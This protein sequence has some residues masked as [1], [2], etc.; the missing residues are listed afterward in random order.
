MA[1]EIQ[2]RGNVIPRA[3][4]V[5]YNM[6]LLTHLRN[7]KVWILV[8]TLF[9]VALGLNISDFVQYHKPF[10]WVL[11]LLTVGLVIAYFSVPARLRAHFGKIYDKTPAISTKTDFLFT[12]TQVEA[13]NALSHTEIKWSGFIG[14]VA[15]RDWLMLHLNNRAFFALDTQQLVSPATASDLTS[16]LE[17]QNI[18]F[19]LEKV[20]KALRVR[21]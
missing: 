20:V 4:Y 11:C 3:I 15:Y 13:R 17:Q 21:A 2:L 7:R 14:V 9:L 1:P 6:Q 12:P 10:P 5:E 18:P 19:G 8:A 16:L